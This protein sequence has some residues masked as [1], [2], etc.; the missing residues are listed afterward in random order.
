[1]K[2]LVIG[3]TKFIGRVLAEQLL[4]LKEYRVTILNRGI[5]KREGFP[6]VEFLKADRTNSAMMKNALRDRFF[7]VVFDISGYTAKDVQIVLDAISNGIGHYV[8]CSSVAVCRQPP[9]YWPL[10]ENHQK[11]SSID[12]G[13][14]GFDK[15]QA[16][17]ILWQR[18]KEGQL[19]VTIVRPVYVYGPYDY[20][21]RE[22]FVFEKTVLDLPITISGN[23]ENIVQFGYVYDL[24]EAM[25]VMI[26]NSESYGQ[27]F[28][29]SGKELVTV[30]QFISLAARAVSKEAKVSYL[31]GCSTDGISDLARFPSVH[32]F[33][34]ISKAEKILGIKPKT[35]LQNGLKETADWWR[36]KKV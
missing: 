16:E 14:Y 33:A 5:S 34:D 10:T 13:K 20:Q 4:K 29:I 26:G 6:F 12:D 11:C 3:G 21:K 18:W 27:S 31:D 19:K 25:I 36:S 2:I 15:W 32:R 24:A 28:N 7:D 17:K 1:M 9:N 22:I 35:D 30:N 23:G 8:F